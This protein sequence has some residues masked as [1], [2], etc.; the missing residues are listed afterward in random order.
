IC[1]RWEIRVGQSELEGVRIEGQLT[2]RDERRRVVNRATGCA[3]HLVP[4]LADAARIIGFD[5]HTI[6]DFNTSAMSALVVEG[7]V[8]DAELVHHRHR[9]DLS[10]GLNIDRDA[11]TNRALPERVAQERRDG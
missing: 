10:R 6:A 8:A 5:V 3:S 7:G 1:G 11:G 9:I 4:K 2:A